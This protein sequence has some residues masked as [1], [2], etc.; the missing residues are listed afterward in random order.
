MHA[1]RNTFSTNTPFR[2]N[3]YYTQIHSAYPANNIGIHIIYPMPYHCHTATPR[4]RQSRLPQTIHSADNRKNT[5]QVFNAIHNNKNEFA[6]MII[7][8]CE[9]EIPIIR[10]TAE[11]RTVSFHLIVATLRPDVKVGL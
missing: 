6:D 10:L 2:G 11:T 9:A 7:D 4:Y 3:T 1:A 5:P 8:R